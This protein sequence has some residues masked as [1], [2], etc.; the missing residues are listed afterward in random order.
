MYCAC[1]VVN[2]DQNVHGFRKNQKI[3]SV[4]GLSIKRGDGDSSDVDAAFR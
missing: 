2:E 1:T 4:G 3:D